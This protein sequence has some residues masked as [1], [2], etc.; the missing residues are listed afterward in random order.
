MAKDEIQNGQ[1]EHGIRHVMEEEMRA[2]GQG[3]FET[4]EAYRL[5]RKAEGM[6]VENKDEGAAPANKSAKPISREAMRTEPQRR[7]AAKRKAR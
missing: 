1:V 3:V 5:R 4:D 2:A 6:A 7:K